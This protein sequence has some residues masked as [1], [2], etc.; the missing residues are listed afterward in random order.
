MHHA[1]PP[2]FNIISCNIYFTQ[3][4]RLPKQIKLDKNAEYATIFGYI[5]DDATKK[6]NWWNTSVLIKYCAVHIKQLALCN[7][8]YYKQ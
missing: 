6:M 8:E 7:N 2:I 1:R 4:I 5:Q 3:L